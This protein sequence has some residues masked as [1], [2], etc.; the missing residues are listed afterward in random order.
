MR[1]S[2]QSPPCKR[3][4][5]WYAVLYAWMIVSLL[6][7]QLAFGQST[8]DLKSLKK[9]LELVKEGQKAIQKDLQEIKNLL[10]GGQAP[11][12]QRQDVVL[13]TGDSAFKGGK[14]AP[15]TLIEFSDYQCPFCS[16]H[17]TETLPQIERDYIKTGKV[18]YV[19]HDFPIESI[20]PQAFK[21]AEAARCAGEQGKYWEMHDQLFAN[22]KA[23]T[24]DDLTRHAQAV[25]LDVTNFK[26]CLNSGKNASHIRGAMSEGAKFGVTGTP[27]F[28]LGFTDRGDSPVKALKTL[29]GAQPYSA[30]RE[31]IE[32]L[33][34]AQTQ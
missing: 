30:F 32:S 4:P 31:A 25:A 28:F 14:D 12:A 13:S 10:R 26:Q 3:H 27:T 8:E 34:T 9:E 20:H 33:L 15:L 5:G 29:V 18:K 21:A 17:F 19:F 22:Q 16:R 7:S 23:L 1:R 11:K 2:V 6:Y 24:P